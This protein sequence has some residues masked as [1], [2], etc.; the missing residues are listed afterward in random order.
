MWGSVWGFVPLI[1]LSHQDDGGDVAIVLVGKKISQGLRTHPNG[2]VRKHHGLP[3]Q[4]V[5]LQL[6]LPQAVD[7]AHNIGG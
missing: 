2:K 1:A 6:A 3:R 7:R 4:G 5:V